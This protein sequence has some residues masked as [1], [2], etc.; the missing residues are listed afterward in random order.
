MSDTGM[1]FILNQGWRLGFVVLF[2]ILIRGVLKRVTWRGASYLLWCSIPICYFYIL[3][4]ECFHVFYY[5]VVVKSSNAPYFLLGEEA[6]VMFKAVWVTVFVGMLLY[7]GYAYIKTNQFTTRSKHLRENIYITARGDVPFTVGVIKPKIY[8][9]ADMKEEFYEPVICHEKVHI[10]R[11]DYLVKNLAFVLLAINWFQPLMWLAYY[12]FVKDMEVTCDEMVLRN[13]PLE[14]RKQYAKALLESST[15][16]VNVGFVATGYGSVS[17]KERVKNI[18]RNQKVSSLKRVLITV[19]CMVIILLSIPM[20]W[21]VRN[22]FG[23]EP[24]SNVS[25]NEVWEVR[26]RIYP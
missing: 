16:E 3:G 15:L 14:F 21:S 26:T 7:M 22:A 12:L 13:K 8:L 4:V 18:S 19:M 23:G 24:G 17:L 6:S 9:P 5:K 10:A 2:I 20:C 25:E 11:K 1:L